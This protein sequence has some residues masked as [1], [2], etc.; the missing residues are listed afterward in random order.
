[1]RRTSQSTQKFIIHSGT[2]YT[3]KNN[4]CNALVRGGPLYLTW[5][6]LGT[7]IRIFWTPLRYPM[8]ENP[9]FLSGMWIWI[10][11]Y[12]ASHCRCLRSTLHICL[13]YNCHRWLG[14][15]L[16]TSLPAPRGRL[17][18]LPFQ[19][20]NFSNTYS[21]YFFWFNFRKSSFLKILISRVCFAASCS[22]ISIFCDGHFFNKL[23]SFMLVLATNMSSPLMTNIIWYLSDLW[24]QQKSF[25]HIL[26]LTSEME[27]KF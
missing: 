12:Q 4:T 20:L 7:W 23:I 10:W 14:E 1:M 18:L 21:K 9:S 19:H 11:N 2:A 5:L 25:P 3:R 8:L 15:Q 16:E 27:S 17:V 26:K 22:F 13:F 6:V 24:Q